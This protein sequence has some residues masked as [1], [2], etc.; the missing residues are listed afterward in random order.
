MIE[1][2]AFSF[3]QQHGAKWKEIFNQTPYL[4]KSVFR[5]N[6]KNPVGITAITAGNV[7]N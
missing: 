4:V 5:N 7:L 3:T 2:L 6:F 1:W